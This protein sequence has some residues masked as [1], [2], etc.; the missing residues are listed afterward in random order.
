[1]TRAL[2]LDRDGVINVERDFVYRREEFDF[3]H[4]IFEIVRLARASKLEVFVVTNQSGI[5]RGYYS[6]AKFRI[7]TDWMCAEF[8]ARN[9]PI[10]KVYHCPFHPDYQRDEFSVF[11]SWR[12]PEPGMFLQ[13][14]AE[15]AIDLPRS[16]MIGD[17]SSDAFAARRAGIENIMLLGSKE[18]FDPPLTFSVDYSPDLFGA[19]TWLRRKIASF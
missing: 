13:A 12:K 19:A 8:A 15:F 7:L 18:D 4:G 1:M 2:F 17:R 10:T 11:A 6:Q 16:L 14:E 5:A 9:A 3:Q